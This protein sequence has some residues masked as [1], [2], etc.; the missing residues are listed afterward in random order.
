MGKNK[1]HISGH[2]FDPVQGKWRRRIN[3]VILNIRTSMKTSFSWIKIYILVDIEYHRYL[4]ISVSRHL[5]L[6]KSMVPIG[7]QLQSCRPESWLLSDTLIL[8]KCISPISLPTLHKQSTKML[9]MTIVFDFLFPVQLFCIE[10]SYILTDYYV[11]IIL[12]VDRRSRTIRE[13]WKGYY[14]EK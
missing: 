9:V 6:W 4:S 5:N 2:N 10:S 8:L 12:R 13:I 1:R 7:I 3:Y 11:L 14:S